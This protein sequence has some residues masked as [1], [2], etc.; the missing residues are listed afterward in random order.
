MKPRISCIMPT[1]RRRH[2][3]PRALACYQA[4]TYDNRE[5]VV[6]D[7]GESAIADLIPRDDRT[8]RYYHVARNQ[9]FTIGRLRNMAADVTNGDLVAHFDDDDYQSPDRLAH[10]VALFDDPRVV[11]AGYHSIWFWDTLAADDEPPLLRYEQATGTALGA[12]LIYRRAHWRQHPFADTSDGEDTAFQTEAVSYGRIATLDGATGF[13]LIA[14]M[15]ELSSQRNVI[16][17]LV[18]RRLE[19]APDSVEAWK[20]VRDPALVNRARDLLA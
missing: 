13:H 6:V 16:H 1:A 8:I 2:F 7:S 18:R 9:E 17:D 19:Q 3:L 11:V 4:Q 14:R 10:Q 20:Q 15:H 5:L 12:S